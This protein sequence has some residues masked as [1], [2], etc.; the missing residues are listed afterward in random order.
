MRDLLQIYALDSVNVNAPRDCQAH[1]LDGLWGQE[2]DRF[3]RRG[4]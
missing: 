2:R 4:R 1:V 3:G